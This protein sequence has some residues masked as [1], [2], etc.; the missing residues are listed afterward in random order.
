MTLAPNP[1]RTLIVAR[2]ELRRR[3]RAV[4]DDSRRAAVFALA[5]FA[6]LLPALLFVFLAYVFGSGVA[7]GESLSVELARAAIVAPILFGAFIGVARTAGSSARPDAAD[8]LLTAVPHRDAAAGMALA[9]VANVLGPFSAFVVVAGLAFAV[10]AGSV[11]AAVTVP[12]AV[13]AAVAVGLLAGVVV[14]VGYH[15]AV[16]RVALLARFRMLVSVLLFGA[17]MLVIL[18]D[19]GNDAFGTVLRTLADSPLGWYGD[20]A[21]VSL[22]LGSTTGAVAAVALTAVSLPA[23]LFLHRSLTERL[24]FGD[25]ARPETGGDDA[26]SASAMATTRAT[27]GHLER[28]P[29]VSRPA[30]TVA[31]KSLRRAWRAPIQLFYVVY[32]LFFAIVPLQRTV[33]AESISTEMLVTLVVYL[34]WAAGAA[35]TLNPL[36]DEGAVLPVTLTTPLSGRAFVGGRALAGVLLGV[37]VVLVATAVAS[38]VS[39]ATPLVVAAVAALGVVLAVCATAL[40]AGAGSAFPKFEASRV[41]RS[42]EAVMP[43]LAAFAFYSAL[44]L[45]AAAPG[46]LASLAVVREFVASLLSLS[47]TLV[48]VA[49][50]VASAVLAGTLAAVSGAYAVR[51]FERYHL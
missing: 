5:A 29:F 4:A 47:P 6:S 41:T 33:A 14:G 16:A 9:E 25:A 42:R 31:E 15:L 34:A 2:T 35:F 11:V 46:S 44:F 32:P 27:T 17:Y 21:Y 1:R 24:W 39:S 20:L 13:L 7:E 22:P 51:A 8:L 37:P 45:A 19:S 18:S 10:G 23:L 28:L 38:L 49:G 30:A 36:G 26:T 50:L 43:G 3:A 12:L 40:A 48:L